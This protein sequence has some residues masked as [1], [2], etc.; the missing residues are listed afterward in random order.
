MKT[1]EVELG[2]GHAAAGCRG[3]G[4]VFTCVTAFDAHQ[5]MTRGGVV[6][7]LPSVVG[8]VRK[9]SGKWGWKG[10]D[11][12]FVRQLENSEAGKRSGV[13]GMSLVSPVGAAC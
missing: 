11:Y 5:R 2:S 8:L 10:T 6:C 4:K 12:S 1:L 13:N 9:P 7:L 3:C